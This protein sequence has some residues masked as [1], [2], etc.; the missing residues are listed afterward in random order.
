MKKIYLTLGVLS[1]LSCL[2][3]KA[4]QNPQYTQY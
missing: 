1:L 4:Q 2:E 3:V